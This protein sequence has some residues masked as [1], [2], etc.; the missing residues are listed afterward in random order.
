M[1]LLE[2]VEANPLI[3]VS[4]S[5]DCALDEEDL[6]NENETVRSHDQEQH[7]ERIPKPS[8]WVARP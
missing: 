1:T 2:R 5:M 4:W 3:R 6:I 7:S 8:L